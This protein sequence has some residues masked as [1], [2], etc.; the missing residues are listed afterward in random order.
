[1]TELTK[2][3]FKRAVEI[4]KANAVD[5]DSYTLVLPPNLQDKKCMV[6]NHGMID[7]MFYQTHGETHSFCG[8][9]LDYIE[10]LAKKRNLI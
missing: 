3:D 9:N 2:E 6:C 7:C 1:M 4:L 8:D 5:T 10:H